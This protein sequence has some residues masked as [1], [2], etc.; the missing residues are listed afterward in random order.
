MG[1]LS[2]NDFAKNSHNLRFIHLSFAIFCTDLSPV[3]YDVF[4]EL[5]GQIFGEAAMRIDRNKKLTSHS[6]N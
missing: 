6:F 3:I 5:F 2:E 4:L 1:L